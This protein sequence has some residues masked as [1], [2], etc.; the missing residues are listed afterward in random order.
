MSL[1]HSSAKCIKIQDHILTFR[2]VN[3]QKCKLFVTPSFLYYRQFKY[4]NEFSNKK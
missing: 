3:D 1:V 2:K 4:A